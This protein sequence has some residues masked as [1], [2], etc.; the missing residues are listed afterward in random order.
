MEDNALLETARE[1]RIWKDAA[2]SNGRLINR[3][4]IS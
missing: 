1:D 4:D 3:T 2:E